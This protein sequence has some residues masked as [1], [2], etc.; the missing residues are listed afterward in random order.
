MKKIAFIL[1]FW[2]T[3]SISAQNFE[4]L[5]F[6]TDST[7]DVISWNMENF[8]KNGNTTIQYLAEI[9]TALDVD[10]VAL[11]ELEETDALQQLIDLLPDYEGVAG[12]DNYD[13]LAYIYNTNVIH[14]NE[15]YEIYPSYWNPFPRPPLV[16]DF[17]FQNERYILINNHLKCCGDDVL[18]P[19]D[20][21]DEEFRRYLAC[22]LLKAYCDENLASE[23]VIIVGDW[24]DELD[25]EWQ[26]NVFQS[27]FDDSEHYLFTDYDIA[28]GSS[29][30]WSYP[31]WPS[32][33]DHILITQPLFD[34]FAQTASSIDVLKIDECFSAW[35]QYDQELSDHRPVALKI[36]PNVFAG[37]EEWMTENTT[38]LY[39]NPANDRIN[40][41]MGSENCEV[42]FQLFDVLGH[43][44]I[45]RFVNAQ[46]TD[47]SISALPS[48][49]YFY[50]ITRKNK[51]SET[52]KLLIYK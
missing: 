26:N 10:I 1:S 43:E 18:N 48:G 24:N 23:N 52:G 3:F 13:E 9:I 2:I 4:N 34:D 20:S 36:L 6:G 15:I 17:N 16:F 28:I 38:R 47:F 46:E 44:K 39:P 49:I 41:S 33:L 21:N 12:S 22:N 8:P 29:A 40:L 35:W 32:H 42:F 50:C 25:D 27:F 14:N 45:A 30:D 37:T 11:Q 51:T 7:L 5:H 31:S 19:N